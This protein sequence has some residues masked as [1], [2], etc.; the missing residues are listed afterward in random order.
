MRNTRIK[1]KERID[2]PREKFTKYG[3]DK[4]P[5]E[6]LLALLLTSGTKG[7]N[8]LSLSREILKKIRK[9][10]NEEITADDLQDIRGLGKVKSQQ[11]IALLALG[12]RLHTQ[13]KKEV[14]TNRDVWKLCN[15]FYGSAQEHLAAFYL[16][17]R[18]HLIQREIVFIGSLNESVAHPRDIFE[19]ALLLNAAS[20]VIAHNHPS[21]KLEPSEADIAITRRLIESGNMLGITVQDHLIVTPKDFLSMRR[22][23][24]VDF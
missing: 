16:D 15:D 5:D 18:S 3:P 4:L 8:V 12:K 13:S 17:T 14:L 24:L 6:E 22:E 20:L 10:G 1:D 9:V 7:K 11:V 19:K 2:L 21:E 23:G